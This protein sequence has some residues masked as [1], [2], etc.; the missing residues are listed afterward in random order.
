MAIRGTL[1]QVLTE[2]W[3]KISDRNHWVQ[4]MSARDKRG[5]QVSVTDTSAIAW[6]A[7]G[8]LEVV[9]DDDNLFYGGLEMLCQASRNVTDCDDPAL[10]NDT[11]GHEAIMQVY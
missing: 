1:R 5:N 9:V 11:L 4:G 6:C 2:A 10:V 7:I 3:Q 8:A